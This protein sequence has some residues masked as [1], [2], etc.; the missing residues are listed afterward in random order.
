M[1]Q[2]ISGAC[3]QLVVNIPDKSLARADL[4]TY[5]EDLVI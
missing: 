4:L 1:G 5:I 2:E 3:G